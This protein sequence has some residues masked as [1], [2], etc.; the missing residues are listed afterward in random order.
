MQDLGTGYITLSVHPSLQSSFTQKCSNTAIWTCL[1]DPPGSVQGGS[2]EFD[3]NRQ[4]K[5]DPARDSDSLQQQHWQDRHR[6]SC[7][8]AV[9]AL[10]EELCNCFC[11]GYMKQ[12]EVIQVS[13]TQHAQVTS[14]SWPGVGIVT[15]VMCD[16][17]IWKS[18]TQIFNH[19]GAK[20]IHTRALM[21]TKTNFSDLYT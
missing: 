7:R 1:M 2:Q 5:D 8:H 15:K 4:E 10:I 12:A 3:I 6:S 11:S 14:P 19:C 18:M 9:W 17:Q 20:H 21:S 13:R 16:L